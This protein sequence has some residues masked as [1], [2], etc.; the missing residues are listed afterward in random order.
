MWWCVYFGRWW[1]VVV[2]GGISRC[3]GHKGVVEGLILILLPSIA[4]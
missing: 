4:F 1:V 3:H 2:G